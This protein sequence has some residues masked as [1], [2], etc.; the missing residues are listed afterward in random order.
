MWQIELT[1]NVACWYRKMRISPPDHT[2]DA[3]LPAP[4][5]RPPERERQPEREQNPQR[6]EAIDPHEKWIA[7]EILPVFDPFHAEVREEPTDVG[8]HEASDRSQRTISVTDVRQD[9]EIARLIGQRVM[10][11]MVGHP[12]ISGP[13]MVMQPRS[14]GSP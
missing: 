8:M 2:L 12:L 11:A 6:V 1:E 3:S 13:C 7:V 9:V 10:L 14:R 5:D 4:T